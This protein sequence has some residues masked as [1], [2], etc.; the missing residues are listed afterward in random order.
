MMHP[1][2]SHTKWLLIVL[3]LAFSAGA[4]WLL[5]TRLDK[6][7]MLALFKSADPLWLLAA[8]VAIN[9]AQIASA[10]RQGFYLKAEKKDAGL[11]YNIALYYVGMLFNHVLPG[12]VGGDGYKTYRLKRDLGIGVKAGIRMMLV[13][14]A[15]GLLW[16]IIIG[17]GFALCSKTLPGIIPYT[18]PLIVIAGIIT[19][20][21]YSVL[22]RKLLKEK[23]AVQLGASPYSFAVQGL[24]AVCAAC[25]FAALSA[26][27][28]WTE[29]GHWADYLMLFMASCFVAVLPVSVGG[30]GLRELTFYF[31]SAWLGLNAEAGVAVAL[32]YFVVNLAA[33][34]QGLI[35]FFRSPT[36]RDMP[37]DA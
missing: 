13:N 24:V 35:F 15:N 8:F 22:S 1:M 11:G 4:L 10:L 26:Q 23:P 31:G 32:L 34:L 36:Y 7:K 5:Y 37:P 27:H 17:L 14:R 29:G 20:V 25:L 12:G 19:I 6:E 2:K 18:A 30:V 21:S 28:P 3:K 16:L 9:A 33:A